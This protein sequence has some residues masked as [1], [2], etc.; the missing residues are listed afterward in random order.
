LSAVTS[1]K[2]K[3]RWL[4]AGL[5]VGIVLVLVPFVVTIVNVSRA[6]DV[7]GGLRQATHIKGKEEDVGRA[8]GSASLSAVLIPP[9]ILLTVLCGLGLMSERRRHL[10]RPRDDGS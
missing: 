2:K 6:S 3:Q 10:V 4:S 8:L 7:Q 5:A 9:G 1:P